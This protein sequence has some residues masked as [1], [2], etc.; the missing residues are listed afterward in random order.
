MKRILAIAVAAILACAGLMACSGR[1]DAEASKA[2]AEGNGKIQVIATIFPAYDWVMSILGDKKTDAD[3][4]LLLDNGV[5]LHSYQPTAEDISKIATCD[6]FIYVGGESDEWVEDALA[7]AVNKDMVVINMLEVLGDS[8]KNEEIVEGMEHEHEHEDGED[9]DADHDH[10][11]EEAD[12]HVWLSLRNAKALCSEFAVALEKVTPENKD[13]YEANLKAYEDKLDELDAKYE[14]AVKNGSKDTILFGDRFPF[15]YL[16][17][18]Y[19]LN[20]F[21]AFAGCSAETEASFETVVFLSEKVDELELPAILKI[22]GDND[23]LANTIKDNTSGKDQAILTMD[24]L[25]AT[26]T[27]DYQAGRTYLSVMEENLEVLKEA[28]K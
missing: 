5:D 24:S 19:N 14:E 1:P 2:E 26:S 12:E 8:V 6:V 17:D 16:V 25:Q 18:D 23:K 7:Q 11:G 9:E 3:V 15:R 10:D 22:E 21:A 27:K 28:L 20:Y 4:T 13:A